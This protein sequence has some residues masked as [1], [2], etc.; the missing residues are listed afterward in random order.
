MRREGFE[1]QVSAPQVIFKYE[2]N[3]KTEPIEQVI[4]NVDE[5]LSGAVIDMVANKK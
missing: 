3:Q 4:I 2:G 5:K 1:I